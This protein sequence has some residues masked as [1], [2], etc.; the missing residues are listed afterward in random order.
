MYSI[1]KIQNIITKEIYV[2][3]T[4]NIPVRWYAHKHFGVT[5]NRP[6]RKSMIEY[7]SDNFIFEILEDCI[8]TKDD[9]KKRENYYI[10]TLNSLIPNGFNICMNGGKKIYLDKINT[11]LGTDFK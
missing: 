3:M 4:Q 7:G 5:S 1:Y 10:Y 8:V 9:A 2:G 11:A 6:F